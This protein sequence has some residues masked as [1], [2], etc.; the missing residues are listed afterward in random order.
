MIDPQLAYDSAQMRNLLDSPVWEVLA[1]HLERM[2]STALVRVMSPMAPD[3]E[4]HHWRGVYTMLV[5]AINLPHLIIER[6]RAQRE[7]A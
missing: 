4:T 6:E 5:D 7:D 3:Q 2:Q 1:R